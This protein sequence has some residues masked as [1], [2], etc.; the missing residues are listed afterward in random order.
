MRTDGIREMI[1]AKVV[2]LVEAAFESRA[3]WTED[4][5]FYVAEHKAAALGRAV[6]RTVLQGLLE[7]LGNGHCGHRNAGRDG[8]VRTFS[9]YAEKTYETVVGLV[10]VRCAAVSCLAGVGPGH[11]LRGLRR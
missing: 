3:S 6:A 5:G 9:K 11:F 1:I 4:G 7:A 8:V 10:T 2:G